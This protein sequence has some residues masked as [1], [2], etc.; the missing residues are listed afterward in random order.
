MKLVRLIICLMIYCNLLI[1]PRARV[2]KR[3]ISVGKNAKKGQFPYMV[4]LTEPQKENETLST[5][6][7]CGGSL[8][9][10]KWILTA[11]Q[12]FPDNEDL[13]PQ[14]EKNASMLAIMG[15]LIS[16][17]LNVTAHIDKIIRNPD[18]QHVVSGDLE[19]VS[20]DIALVRTSE[21]FK[22]NENIQTIT[23]AAPALLDGIPISHRISDCL[24]I[25][26]GA[27]DEQDEKMMPLRLC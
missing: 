22:L 3:I 18:Y 10:P 11:G 13:L 19:A 23:L 26:F 6:N 15:N 27:S 25:G 14:I 4:Q 1:F 8:I 24:T 9:H 5:F 16:L 21:E 2:R 17:S 20:D 7:V 12:C